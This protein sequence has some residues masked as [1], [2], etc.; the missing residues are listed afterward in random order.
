MFASRHFAP[1]NCG[2]C[3]YSL[4]NFGLTVSKYDSQQADRSIIYK[5][6]VSEYV[7]T[8]SGISEITFSYV[9]RIF[10][11]HFLMYYAKYE[12]YGKWIFLQ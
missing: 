2:S 5:T 11:M 3:D 9:K 12:S 7:N 4:H 6:I 1:P 8:C 10:V